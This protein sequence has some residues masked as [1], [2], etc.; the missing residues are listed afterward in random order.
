M[1]KSVKKVIR[2]EYNRLKRAMEKMMKPK[3][4]GAMPSLIL[5]PVRTKNN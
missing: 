1:A 3:K 2:E 5:Q 4:Q